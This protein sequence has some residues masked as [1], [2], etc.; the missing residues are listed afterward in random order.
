MHA[1]GFT[2]T[3]WHFIGYLHLADSVARAPVF[4]DGDP[5][6]PLLPE[7]HDSAR[8]PLRGLAFDEL[9]SV[10]IAFHETPA[11]QPQESLAHT[12]SPAHFGVPL[13]ASPFFLPPPRPAPFHVDES[14]IGLGGQPRVIT[15]E[16]RE[17][18]IETL[19]DIRQV[20]L[21]TDRDL[22]TSDAIRH[23]DGSPVVPPE[24]QLGESFA[25][26]VAQANEVAPDGVADMTS[27]LGS[28]T[29]EIVAMIAAR[30]AAWA[31]TGSPHPDGGPAGA[32]PEGRVVDGVA[33]APDPDAPTL[34]EIAPWRPQEAPAETVTEARLDL[35]APTGG[36][37]TLAETGL[38]SQINAAVIL[39]IN[40]AV[41]SMVVAGDYFYSRGI[42]QVNILVDNDHV[43]I[44]TAGDL[45]PVVRTAGNEV[46]NIAE[47][48]T[49]QSTVEVRGAAATPHW[50]VDVMSG[51]FYDVKSIVQFNGLDD[52]DRTVQ[53]DS[54][55]YFNLGTG[56]NQQINLTKITGIDSYDIIVIGG[57]YHRADWIYQYNIVLDPDYATLYA[58]GGEDGDTTV[59]TGLNSLTN[60]ATIESWDA[61]AFK[62]MLDAHHEL[63]GLLAD[64]AT[65]LVPDGDWQLYGSASGTLRILYIPGDYYDVNVV[66]Q[67]NFLVDGDQSIQASASADT[68]QGVAAGGN[69]ALNEAYI[70]DPG[71]LSTSNYLGGQAYEEVVLIQVN[72]VTDSDT[73]TIHDTSTLVPELVAFAQQAG[74]EPEPDC[75]PVQV[76]DPA[77]HD[78]LTSSIMV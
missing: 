66:T 5:P 78:H 59:T 2:E 43:D 12:L 44:A 7:L 62:P 48:V 73:V 40:E 24:L 1:G 4:Y 71:L 25:A 30:D 19:I 46:H 22:V 31:Q 69:S 33:G 32:A 64:G 18:G 60:K 10:P 56:E 47:F 35:A 27:A 51:D 16:Y 34:L 20:N 36:V 74:Q 45:S 17:G 9:A 29:G 23:A 26:L 15:V 13:R 41:G 54:G 63:M 6:P 49:H 28:G 72:I 77:Q 58:A 42:V 65:V 75:P 39:D 70:V 8:E 55:T 57:D 68:G 67:V 61:T 76:V 52:N 53:A 21:E 11:S 38:N 37:A 3:I 14:A 50:V